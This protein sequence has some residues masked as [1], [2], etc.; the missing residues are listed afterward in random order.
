MNSATRD[1]LS[2][3][4]RVLEQ[5]MRFELWL[6]E[7]RRQD[8]WKLAQIIEE[9]TGTINTDPT[10]LTVRMR[11]MQITRQELPSLLRLID[12]LDARLKVSPNLTRANRCGATDEKTYDEESMC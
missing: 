1:E 6:D 10:T 12:E 2:R 7:I 8:F 11:L 3:I 5:C 9:V 4:R